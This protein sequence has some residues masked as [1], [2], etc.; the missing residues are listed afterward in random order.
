MFDSVRLKGRC[1]TLRKNTSSG[2]LTAITSPRK[3]KLSSAC[4]AVFFIIKMPDLAQGMTTEETAD[5]YRAEIC[6][7]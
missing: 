3:P 7:N 5:I 2:D 1:L 6:N 4:S